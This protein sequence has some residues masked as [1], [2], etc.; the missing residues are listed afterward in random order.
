MSL[1]KTTTLAV[2]LLI[3]LAG[4]KPAHD[5]RQANDK[6]P[7]PGTAGHADVQAKTVFN[8]ADLDR[9]ISA[10]QDLDGFV[11]RTWSLANPV[12]ADR[13]S[14]EMANEIDEKSTAVQR[15]IVEDAA[16]SVATLDQ[17]S[18]AAKLGILYASGMDD[19]A[20]EAAGD[21]P[22]KPQLNEI[23]ALTSSK[24][25][26]DY[27]A[28]RHA[29]GDPQ[30]FNF[31][32]HADFS[33]ATQQIGY[34][35]Q[36]GLIF[37]TK[38]YYSAAQYAPL[39]AAYL[40]YIAK[41]FELTGTSAEAATAQAKQVLALESRL[42]A[43][44]LSKVEAHDPKNQYR[45]V[46]VA[47]ADKATP[48]FS[49]EKFFAT[50]GVTIDKGFSLANSRFFS[51]FDR[52]LASAPVAQWKAYLR[53]HAID[54]A[55][56]LLS[57]PFVDNSFA[58]HATA[59]YGQPEQQARWRRVLTDVNTA[60]GE[61]LGQLYVAKTFTPDSK[62]QATAMVDTLRTAFRARIEK[63]SWMTATTRTRALNKLDALLPNVGYPDTWRDWSGL[64]LKQGAYFENMRAAARFNHRYDMDQLGKPTDRKRWSMTPQTADAYYEWSTNTINLPA[65]FL[66][67]PL[68]DPAADAALN[69]GGIGT[70]IG[71]EL[72]HGFDDVGS[73]FDG[74]GNNV[75]WWT[76][77]DRQKFEARSKRLIDQFDAY[78]PLPNRPELHVNGRLTLGENIADLG[79]LNIAY[80]GLKIALRE[81]PDDAAPIAG[82]SAEQRFF[83]ASARNWRRTIREKQQLARLESD[84]HA[85]SRMRAIASPSNMPQFAQA[86]SCKAGDAMVRPDTD[87]VTIW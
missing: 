3:A 23:D 76:R 53:F 7:L 37:R 79:G 27:I 87:R 45:F 6:T 15:Q 9:S 55:A 60:M 40:E 72:T 31:S 8:A 10:C 48:H 5:D 29:Q 1:L 11:N 22:L 71:H 63:A 54:G 74:A 61:G 46:S 2:A 81:H 77:V 30:V 18:V 58:F 83:I 44:S 21:Q 24:D 17:H 51:E 13:A 75:D 12:P 70:I 4:C 69:Y 50:Q 35:E 41:S 66:Q 65:A 32:I 56:G 84:P 16:K 28:Q 49:W 67:P 82:Y 57:K 85:P 64:D 47:D 52:Q 42:A 62:R 38:D 33:D 86:F 73:H 36:G 78:Q 43:A 39:R 14:W 34:A 25:I 19:A 80:D 68:F 20:I 26:A 59:L